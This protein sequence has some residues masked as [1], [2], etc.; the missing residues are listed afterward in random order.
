MYQGSSE[1]GVV[2]VAA[3]AASKGQGPNDRGKDLGR[4][5]TKMHRRMGDLVTLYGFTAYHFHGS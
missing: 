3:A 1:D 2:V 5:T 4:G